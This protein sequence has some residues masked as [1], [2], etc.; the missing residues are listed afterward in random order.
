M[1]LKKYLFK[2]LFISTLFMGSSYATASSV[3]NIDLS[4]TGGLTSS[5][6]TV[7]TEAADFWSNIIT[8]YDSSISTV[9]SGF[10]IDVGSTDLGGPGG[11]LAQAS[12]SAVSSFITGGYTLSAGG[13]IEFDLFDVD[14][15]E[16]SDS[17]LDAAI[18]EMGHIIGIGIL[19]EANGLYVAGSG[20]YMGEE[21]L[22]AYQLE[23]DSFATFVPVELE[24]GS[25]TANGHW[26][27]NN[28]GSGATGVTDSNGN[29]MQNELMT[30]WLN[31]SIFL[32]NTT[33]ASLSDLGYTVTVVPVPPSGWLLGIALLMLGFLSRRRNDALSTSR[34]IN[35]V[36]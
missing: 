23:F 26:D 30:G 18:H 1:K 16:S 11:T 4:F 6:Q 14:F 3:F 28:N 7:L 29:D 17:L 19:W 9:F 13:S 27:E 8:G 10:S 5:Q 32:S 25:G 2:I 24:G 34:P 35:S 21:G 22:A 12:T 20:Q 15:L 31:D 36:F 33:L